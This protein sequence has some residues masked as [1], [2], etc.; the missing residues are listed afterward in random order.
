MSTLKFN[1]V[2]IRALA[3]CVPARVI[4]NLTYTDHFRPEEISQVIE[5]IGVI[6]RRFAD[7]A[8]CSSDLCYEAASKILLENAIDPKEIDA[9]LFVSQTPDYR[10]PATSIILQN[11]L[12]LRIDTIAFD[13]NLGCSGFIYGL[14]VAFSLMGNSGIRKILLL[15]GE[16][17]SRVYSS[18]DRQ[19]AFLFGDAGSAALIDR[20][21][22]FGESFFSLNSDGSKEDYIK[23]MAGGSRYP[24]S[25]QTMTERV[26]DENGNIRSDEH[27]FMR[28]GDV[29]TFV[30]KAVPA[31][32]NRILNFAET[33]IKSI[34]YYILHQANK[35]INDHLIRKLKLEQE[36]VPSTIHKF[37]NTS[38]V[39]IPLTIVSELKNM[40]KGKKL[41]LS[42][43]GVG[44]SW[45][46]CIINLD[47]LLI[48][49]L[50][51]L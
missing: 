29:F 21:E 10:M 41:L 14:A 16:T 11:R 33:D 23:V 46:S 36:K 17:R 47:K 5:K 34:D 42:G 40:A 12:G 18:K 7:D 25:L 44:M 37:G 24:T 20:S 27:G 30:I 49:E 1:G 26:V 4:R 50:V 13:I 31:D 28:G 45:G 6:E 35:F 19:A 22:S 3:A 51:E 43:F 9:L 32:I 39:S 8:I 2:G 15:N 48:S 38:S